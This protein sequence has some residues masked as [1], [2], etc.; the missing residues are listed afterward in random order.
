[1]EAH[2][3]TNIQKVD[4]SKDVDE[5][6]NLPE[7]V[8]KFLKRKRQGESLSIHQRSALVNMIQ[9]RKKRKGKEMAS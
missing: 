6:E 1:M 2:P 5:E 7:C 8:K 4:E 3:E 9:S